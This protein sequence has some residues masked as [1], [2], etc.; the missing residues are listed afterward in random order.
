MAALFVP[1]LMPAANAINAVG[2]VTIEVATCGL[3]VAAGNPVNYGTLTLGTVS[4]EQTLNIE[5]LGNTPGTLMISGAN[6]K[7]LLG[8]NMVDVMDVGVITRI[9]LP[10]HTKRRV[11]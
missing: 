3:T 1:A 11:F 9:R 4:A 8:P 6:W 7:G 2:E 5:N 10:L